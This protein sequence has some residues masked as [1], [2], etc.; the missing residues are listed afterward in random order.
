MKAL[1]SVADEVRLGFRN[2]NASFDGVGRLAN[3]MTL[4][5]AQDASKL[6][7]FFFSS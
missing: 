6:N 3:F 7:T 1:L 5:V 2:T 4:F